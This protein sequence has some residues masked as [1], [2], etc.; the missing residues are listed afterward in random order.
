MPFLQS[1]INAFQRFIKGYRSG[2]GHFREA[3]A[4]R[5]K[6]GSSVVVPSYSNNKT[7]LVERLAGSQTYVW[8]YVA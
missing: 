4:V 6:S 3:E 2:V 5:L 7:S 1:G 8:Q